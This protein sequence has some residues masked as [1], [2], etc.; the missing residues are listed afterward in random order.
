MTSVAKFNFDYTSTALG[1]RW[2]RFERRGGKCGAA[3]FSSPPCNYSRFG[4]RAKSRSFYYK[5][6]LVR[7]RI[8]IIFFMCIRLFA[9]IRFKIGFEVL[10]ETIPPCQGAMGV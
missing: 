7:K 5:E 4:G 1:A 9:R 3:A 6:I 8:Y 2:F 10:K